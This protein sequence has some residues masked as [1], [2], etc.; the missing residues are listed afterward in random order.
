[1][2]EAPNRGRLR[3]PASSESVGVKVLGPCSSTQAVRQTPQ[4]TAGAQNICRSAQTSNATCRNR[5]LRSHPQ[6]QIQ[7]LFRLARPQCSD[8]ALPGAGPKNKPLNCSTRSVRGQSSSGG[9][10][11]PGSSCQASTRSSCNCC[12]RRCGGRAYGPRNGRWVRR[13]P[14]PGDHEFAHCEG[15]PIH[16][17]SNPGRFQTRGCQR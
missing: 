14:Q 9:G 2:T 4:S 13:F 15:C 1:L 16:R 5:P 11:S 6:P 7:R 12:N 8:V 17:S 10:A 3:L